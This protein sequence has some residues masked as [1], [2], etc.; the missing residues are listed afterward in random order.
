MRQPYFDIRNGS[1]VAHSRVV[2]DVV[3]FGW[4]R[5]VFVAPEVRGRGV[6]NLLVAGI[7]DL[8]PLNL[9]RLLLSTDDANGLYAQHGIALLQEPSKMMARVPW[10]MTYRSTI[11]TP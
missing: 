10:G 1:Q 6:W 7:D 4:L 5:N 3:T 8:E 2:A 9:K 11:V